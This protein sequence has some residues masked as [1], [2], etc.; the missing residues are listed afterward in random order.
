MKDKAIMKKSRTS[1]DSRVNSLW[2]RHAVHQTLESHSVPSHRRMILG[3]KRIK[4]VLGRGLGLA[5]V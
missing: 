3:R 5:R 2:S 4:A 1:A